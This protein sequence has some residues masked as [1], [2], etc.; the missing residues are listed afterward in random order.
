MIAAIVSEKSVPLFV[1]SSCGASH[2]RLF[3]HRAPLR[4]R[5]PPGER[6]DRPAKAGS[7]HFRQRGEAE[8]AELHH[9]P[10]DPQS[11]AQ[12]HPVLLSQR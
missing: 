10:G 12:R 5:G 4:P 9:P 1:E 7:T 8:A 6:G 2:P 3:L 11:N